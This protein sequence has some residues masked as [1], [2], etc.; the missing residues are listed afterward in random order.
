MTLSK[1]QKEIIRDL[2]SQELK[3]LELELE[4][5]GNEEVESACDELETIIEIMDLELEMEN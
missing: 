2:A 4:K 5:S 1:K 3:E